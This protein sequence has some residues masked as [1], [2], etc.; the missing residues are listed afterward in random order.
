MWHP[1]C[2]RAKLSCWN[3]TRKPCRLPCLGSAA[4]SES[5][6]W[7]FP[8]FCVAHASLVWLFQ[9]ARASRGTLDIACG[10]LN[11]VWAPIL[12]QWIS[13]KQTLKSSSAPLKWAYLVSGQEIPSSVVW[14][15]LISID[16]RVAQRDISVGVNPILSHPCW[17][18]L[19]DLFIRHFIC[20]RHP[21]KN[22]IEKIQY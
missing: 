22:H 19:K 10:Q 2:L 15:G 13:S 4:A 3:V 5:C 9:I 6:L 18:E 21:W 14:D 7:V 1:W 16:Q 11:W 20:Y 17:F 12:C 8:T